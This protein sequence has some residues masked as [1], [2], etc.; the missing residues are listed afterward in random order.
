MA[1]SNNS[2][3]I[4]QNRIVIETI[5]K[6]S[7]YSHLTCF[8]E[9]DTQNDI[10]ELRSHV[11]G[12]VSYIF[13]IENSEIIIENFNSYHKATISMKII[14]QGIP[15]KLKFGKNRDLDL[16]TISSTY[17]KCDEN[18]EIT[19]IIQLRNGKIIES[20]CA[21]KYV[22]VLIETSWLVVN[23]YYSLNTPK[24][25]LYPG[26]YFIWLKSFQKKIVC[27]F[28]SIPIF[29]LDEKKKKKQI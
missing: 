1:K 16:I 5:I 20:E 12:E 22:L 28:K 25:I 19:R 6:F 17:T 18:F 9:F 14:D 29:P 2:I 11:S 8:L 15:K 23:D 4:L 21:T 27:F 13:I 3:Q 24:M 7:N 26:K 10:F